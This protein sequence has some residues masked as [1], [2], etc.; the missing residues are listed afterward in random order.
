MAEDKNLLV[1]DDEELEQDAEGTEYVAVDNPVNAET[2]DDEDDEKSLKASDEDDGDDEDEREA[3]RE[4]RRQE[5]KERKERRE[6]AIGRDKIELNF[7]RQRNDELERR[8]MAVETHTKQTSLSDID[9][10]INEAVYEAETAERIIA[11]AVEAGNGEDVTKAL[12][13]RDQAVAKA[14]QL[15]QYKQ[16][17][18]QVAQAPRN[19]VASE[20][21]HYAQEFMKNNKWYDPQGRDEDSA[22]VLAIDN[23]LAQEGFD[24]RTE[25]YWDELETRVERRLPEK[26]A[27]Q[28]RA[29]RKPTGGPAVGSGRE[30]AP[31]STRKEIY[32]SPE[33]KSAMQEAGVWDDPVLRQRYI[34][35]YAEYDRQHKD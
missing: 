19:T 26:F 5:K 20:V 8:M 30:H 9:R 12:R 24:P 34:K 33:R 1:E 4:R 17:Q 27:K 16:Q 31:A 28:E 13:Y 22:I 15:T 11:K 2:D 18:E 7:L 25:E 6:K 14:Q 29:P 35:R 10:Q 3:I 23:K 32:I 21:E